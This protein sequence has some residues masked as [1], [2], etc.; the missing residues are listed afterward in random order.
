MKKLLLILLCL[1]IIGFGQ[2]KECGTLITKEQ[3]EYLSNKRLLRNNWLQQKT[4]LNI[5][6]QHHIVRQSNGNGGLNQNHIDDIMT[7]MNNYYSNSD[8]QFYNCD[9]INYIDVDNFHNF[10]KNYEDILCETY[11]VLNVI[12]IYYFNSITTWSGTAI[13]GYSRFPPSVDRV[14]MDNSC[15]LN[16]STLSHELGHY[17]SLY[18]THGP[19]NSG[20]TTELVNGSNCA[21]EGDELCDTPADPNLSGVVNSNCEYTDSIT[22]LNGDVY[23]P[24]T[25][26]IMSYSL[27]PCRNSLSLQQYNRINFSAINDR[28]Y[29]ICG[30][31]YGCTDSLASNYND[32]ASVDDGS[33]V[34]CTES[35]FSPL[36]LQLITDAF[37]L[38]TS[39]KITNYGEIIKSGL[40]YVSSGFQNIPM[41]NLD[42]GCYEFSIYDWDGL[43]CDYGPG[44]YSLTDVNGNIIISGASFSEKESYAF[45]IANITS[46]EESIESIG[47]KRLVKITDLLGRETKGTKNEVLFYIYDDGTVEKRIVIE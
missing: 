9:S 36:T 6:V 45:E 19:T 21:T 42:D 35:F 27:K 11:D 4:I 46:T 17:F 32:N 22:D 10:H 38:E 24:D 1:P 23:K 37:A 34:Y 40:G 8:V 33:C 3:S 44:S 47:N 31:T 39:W 20:T 13:C 25:S 15:A 29:L 26:N 2:E 5:P 28:W 18:H 7:I 12:N 30:P 41:I 14:F 16:G 43:C